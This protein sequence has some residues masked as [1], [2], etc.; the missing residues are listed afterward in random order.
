[1]GGGSSVYATP[2]DDNPNYL[3]YGEDAEHVFYID[4]GSISCTRYNPPYYAL[5]FKNIFWDYSLNRYL[6]C[7]IVDLYDYDTKNIT[8]YIN[9][10]SY[11]L[12]N[13]E[14]IEESNDQTLQGKYTRDNLDLIAAM[15]FFKYYGISFY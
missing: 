1:M 9:K 15:V 13:G 3:K 7:D 12:E 10:T 4:I 14:L 6:I 2:F 11:Y 5:T 8:S